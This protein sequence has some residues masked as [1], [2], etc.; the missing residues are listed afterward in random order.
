MTRR[1]A[2][3]SLLIRLWSVTCLA[4]LLLLLLGRFNG[5]AAQSAKPTTKVTPA[6][7]ISLFQKPAPKVSVLTFGPGD[8]AF[9]KFGHNAIR[10]QD[11]EDKSDWVYNFGTFRYDNPFLIVDFLTG[12]FQYWLSVASFQRTIA[13]YKEADREIIE[14][15]LN[16]G[17]QAAHE[18]N[19]ALREN[20][21]PENRSYLYDYY[22]DN[23]STRVR[24]A[25][26]RVLGGA[27]KQRSEDPG[28]Y[29]LRHHTLRAVADDFWLYLGL[30]VAMG[31]YIDQPETR[32]TEMFLPEKLHDGMD[33]IVF[34]G[35][36]GTA[37]LVTER[38]V[39][40]RGD[41]AKRI[42]KAPPE[43]TLDFLKAGVAL[44]ALFCFL[45]WEVYRRRK[46]W[47]QATL[48][49][50][51]ALFGLTLG[52]LGCLFLGLWTLTN[53]AVSFHNEN[54]LQCAP[55]ALGFPLAAWGVLKGRSKWI[56]LAY[57]VGQAGV[58]ASVLGL[59]L[60]VFPFMA[61]ENERIIA[62]LLPAWIGVLVALYW[63]RLRSELPAL[64][65]S[66][67]EMQLLND[68][69]STRAEGDPQPV[70]ESRG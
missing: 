30:D 11:P 19:K 15:E 3:C 44:A 49:L 40:H 45:G 12:K 68:A 5:A 50:L 37:K 66:G 26:D 48:A 57:R 34:S 6:F 69:E 65:P 18:L 33:R 52:I 13:Y 55:W 27:L 38:R 62:L 59:L 46:P 53:H 9:L 21:L 35:V 25:I 60:K 43:R 36:H 2:S 22:R 56:K 54:L 1:S 70:D 67:Q 23:C 7:D 64:S 10:I 31:S 41:S 47:A 17:H 58:A 63:M 14:Q 42:R 61:Q 51:L 4:F 24:D 16:V 8:A 32:W 20:A 29:S 28:Q 39:W